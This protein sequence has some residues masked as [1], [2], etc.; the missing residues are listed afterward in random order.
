M[1]TGNHQTLTKQQTI[2]SLQSSKSTKFEV[3]DLSTSREKQELVKV[4]EKKLRNRSLSVIIVD[5]F[6]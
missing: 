5:E 3:H 1:M 4:L 6:L 2:K